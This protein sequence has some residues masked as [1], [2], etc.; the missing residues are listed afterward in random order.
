MHFLRVSW[1]TLD[2]NV[3]ARCHAILTSCSECIFIARPGFPG[4]RLGQTVTQN[5]TIIDIWYIL[6]NNCVCVCVIGALTMIVGQVG[7]GKSSLLLAAL[8]EMQKISGSVTWN[9]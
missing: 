8:G 1:F 7:C 6:L 4:S 5:K 2:V 3:C 9:K